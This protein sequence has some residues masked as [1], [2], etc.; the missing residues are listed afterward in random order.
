MIILINRFTVTGPADQFE[1]VFVGTS[2]FFRRAPGH[3]RNR[4][5]KVSDA[6]TAYV[7]IAEWSDMESLQKAIRQ[8]EFD[9]HA[10]QLR[11]L[12]TAE[13]TVCEVV[14]EWFG[15]QA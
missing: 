1:Q 5:L 11:A 12:A 15:E 7:N 4:L 3:L 8:P 2:E 9:P 10:Q 14:G 13:P 6:P